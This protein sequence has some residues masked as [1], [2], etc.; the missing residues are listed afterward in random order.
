M[1]QVR[2][3]FLIKKAEK[4]AEIENEMQKTNNQQRQEQLF[5]SLILVASK[6]TPDDMV[7]ID[8]YIS[9]HSLIK[10]NFS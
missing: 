3:N 7:F 9:K 6:L 4:I 5:N 10:K 1:K 2:R 8:E